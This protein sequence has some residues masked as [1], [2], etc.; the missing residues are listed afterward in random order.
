MPWNEPVKA[1]LCVCV[2]VCI[3]VCLCVYMVGSSRQIGPTLEIHR[4]YLFHEYC[5]LYHTL[6][7]FCSM[8]QT[9]VGS[10]VL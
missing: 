7:T 5:V 10:F 3:C 2:S 1:Y 4:K 8:M 9:E 6:N